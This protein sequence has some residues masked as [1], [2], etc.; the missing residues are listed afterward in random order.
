MPDAHIPR[1]S[2]QLRQQVGA[3]C[4]QVEFASFYQLQDGGRGELLGERGE[5]VVGVLAGGYMRLEY[6]KAA[7]LAEDGLASMANQDAGAR[8][9]RQAAQVAGQLGASSGG[10]W[11]RLLPG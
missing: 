9:T 5:A 1:R 7:S 2:C 3:G 6:G 10:K 4:F 8:R 11:S